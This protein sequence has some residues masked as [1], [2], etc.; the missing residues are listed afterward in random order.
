MP[1]R[2]F[3]IC[4]A[5]FYRDLADRLVAGAIEEFVDQGVAE[6]QVEVFEVPGAFELPQAA[7]RCARSD[8]YDGVVCL[9]AVIRGE[10][11]HYEHICSESAA[12]IMRVGLD[13][14]T[15]C[16]FGVLTCEDMDQAIAR[17]GGGKRNQG[18]DG[19]AAVLAL[20]AVEPGP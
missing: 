4:V 13:T 9:G 14:G 17:S 1:E 5:T 11:S 6:G 7:L 8:R 19:A 12:G 2:R 3:A 16:S 15:P 20:A 10:T 18:R